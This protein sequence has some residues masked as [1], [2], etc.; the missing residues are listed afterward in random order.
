MKRTQIVLF[1]AA[2]CLCLSSAVAA[3]MGMNFFKKPNIADIFRPV[4]GNG[5]VYEQQRTDMQKSTMEMTVVGT[6]IVDGKEGFWMEFGHGDAKTGQ[7]NYGK[8]LVTKDDFRFHKMII[9]PPGQPAMEMTLNSGDAPGEKSR[10]H[11][12]EELEKWHSVGN[13]TITVPAGTFS[14]VHWK[15]DTGVGDVWF[16]DKISPMGMVK[17]VSSSDTMVL[18]KVISDAKDHIT[19]PVTKFDP[20]ALQRQ[21]MQQRQQQ[22]P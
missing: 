16:S 10:A 19:G 13:E 15:K 9:Q 20:Q 5:A 8:V 11:M 4:V 22:K 7:M 6:E 21:M 18:V 17:S 14:C 1:A 2:G 12:Q 3:Q